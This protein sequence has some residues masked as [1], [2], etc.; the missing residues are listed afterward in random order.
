MISLRAYQR[1]TL[2]LPLPFSLIPNPWRIVLPA[3]VYFVSM[4]IL[5]I[6]YTVHA[7]QSMDSACES[8][9]SAFDRNG[10]IPSCPQLF[11]QFAVEAAEKAGRHYYVS[12]SALY[13][14]FYVCSYSVMVLWIFLS[15]LML[16]RCL[17]GVDFVRHDMEI[18]PI[19][20]L[21]ASQTPT[22]LIGHKSFGE[23]G[24]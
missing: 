11:D 14:V 13:Y 2:S 10:S 8:L 19:S 6:Y 23:E 18:K 16:F 3:F 15:A 5:S 7:H 17:F 4:A 12:A 22:P 24:K 20:V 1:D 21:S 9:A